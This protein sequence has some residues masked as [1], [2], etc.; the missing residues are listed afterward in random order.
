VRQEDLQ[1]WNQEGADF[2]R[3]GL[4]QTCGWWDSFGHRDL[5]RATSG[6]A[7]T[8]GQMEPPKPVNSMSVVDRVRK[9]EGITGYEAHAYANS[10]EFK[11]GNHT[12]CYVMHCMLCGGS[13]CCCTFNFYFG[14]CL[15]MPVCVLGVIPFPC[16]CTCERE[17]NLYVTRDKHGSRTG[18]C[19][20]IDE[21]RGTIGHFAAKCCSQEPEETPCCYLYRQC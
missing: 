5:P 13:P 11:E 10:I 17:G 2:G 14:R 8:S 4:P 21:E 6:T 16:I 3:G 15:C 20:V 1:K 9:M 7:Q 18:T 12:G 19:M